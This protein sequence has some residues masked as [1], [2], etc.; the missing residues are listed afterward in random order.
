MS[1]KRIIRQSRTAGPVVI[2]GDSHNTI[3]IVVIK[4]MGARAL[5]AGFCWRWLSLLGKVP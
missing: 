3:G 1:P 2:R 5:L 4:T